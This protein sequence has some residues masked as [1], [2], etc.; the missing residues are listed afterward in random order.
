MSECRIQV[1]Q[2][3]IDELLEQDLYESC[4]DCRSCTDA[5]DEQRGLVM[6][7]RHGS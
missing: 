1:E 2:Q 5:D 4:E 7:D 6:C 3:M